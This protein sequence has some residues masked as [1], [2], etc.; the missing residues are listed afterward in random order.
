MYDFT[1]ELD[2]LRDSKANKIIN[3]HNRQRHFDG[4]R[5]N[6]INIIDYK[7]YKGTVRENFLLIAEKLKN[8]W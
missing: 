6:R 5:Y 8:D 4:I 3:R 7:D 1:K 2:N